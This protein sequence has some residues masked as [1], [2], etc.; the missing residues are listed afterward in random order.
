[1]AEKNIEIRIV[2]E[3][4]DPFYDQ[5]LQFKQRLGVKNNA[6]VARVILK[7][8]FQELKEGGI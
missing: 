6:E 1:M 2:L 5:F 7:K 4:G 8:G 3:P